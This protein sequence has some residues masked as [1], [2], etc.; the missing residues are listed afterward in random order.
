MRVGPRH[1]ALLV[2][3][4][5]TSALLGVNQRDGGVE[6]AVREAPFVVV[7]GQNLDQVTDNLSLGRIEV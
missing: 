6:H 7:P 3:D 4:D 5:G 2:N 1:V